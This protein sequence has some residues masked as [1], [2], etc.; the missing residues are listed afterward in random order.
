[1]DEH[2]EQEVFR[3]HK[4]RI[5]EL[6]KQFRRKLSWGEEQEVL[7]AMPEYQ[8]LVADRERVAK[9]TAEL[10]EKDE[11]PVVEALIRAGWP[12]EVRQ[13][14]PTRS[15]WDFANTAVA[16]PHLVDVLID[17]FSRPYHIVTREGIARALTVKEARGTEA[18]KLL[19]A[20]LKKRY[21]QPF[22]D[23]FRNMLK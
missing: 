2:Q 23:D 11:Q 9:E 10:L 16:Y 14:G 13:C 5:A 3:K 22:I 4:R 17:H 20:E 8:Q 1:M 19:V 18:Q 21:I 12:A 6:N 7:E 15:V